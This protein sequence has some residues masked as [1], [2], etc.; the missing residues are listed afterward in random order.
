MTDKNTRGNPWQSQAKL[1]DVDMRFSEGI[2]DQFCSAQGRFD[3]ADV[4]PLGK[5]DATLG[6]IRLNSPELIFCRH[7]LTRA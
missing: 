4:S 6:E 7:P 1:G 3:E 2:L 5:S